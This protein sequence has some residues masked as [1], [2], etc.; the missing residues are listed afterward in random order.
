[1]GDEK[2]ERESSETL[3]GSTESLN[4]KPIHDQTFNNGISNGIQMDDEKLEEGS[5]ESP[6]DSAES[7]QTEALPPPTY[8]N[9]IPNGG[10]IAWLQVLGSFFMFMNSWYV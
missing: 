7:L 3:S 4:V 8:N 1:M 9:E 5:P 6:S 2:I 10:L